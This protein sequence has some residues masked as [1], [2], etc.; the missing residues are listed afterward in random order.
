[1]RKQSKGDGNGWRII[2]LLLTLCVTLLVSSNLPS[3]VSASIK[4]NAQIQLKSEESRGLSFRDVANHWAQQTI[5]WGTKHHIVAGYE[6]GTFKPNRVVTE[7]EFLVMLLKAYPDQKLPVTAGAVWYDQYFKYASLQN[8]SILGKKIGDTHQFNRGQVAQLIASTQGQDLDRAASIQFL[9]DNGLASGKTS[10]S[11]AGFG[12]ND[13]L[14]RAEALQ[15]IRNLKDKQVPLKKA[16]GK[17]SEFQVRGIAIG[18]SEQK[19]LD[20][21]GQPARKDASEYAF[22]WYIYN[23]D[24]SQ[25]AQIGIQ[26]QKVVALYSNSGAWSS[27]QGITVGSTPASVKA[28]YG[29]PL[30]YLEKG[31]TRFLVNGSEDEYGYYLIDNTYTTLFFDVHH[32]RSVTAVLIMDKKVEESLM[33]FYGTSSSELVKSYELQIWDMVNAIRTRMGK[34]PLAWD[35][36]ASAS[37]KKHSKDMAVNGFFHHTNLKGESPFER[38]EKEGIRYMLASENIATGQRNAIFVH[39]GWMNSLGHRQNV[40]GDVTRLGTGV[41]FGGEYDVYYTQNFYTPMP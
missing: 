38:M 9:L 33:D 19:V 8:W 23:Q 14:T 7:A 25:Y 11:T 35:D 12:A 21:L 28:A 6:D 26:N 29:E 2:G 40:L 1:M 17:K 24:Y 30:D 13:R 10:Q 20:T 32:D 18:D 15:L 36:L 4:T 5:T 22:K 3:S 27:K 16:P 31:N 39:E 37:S 41:Y 34:S